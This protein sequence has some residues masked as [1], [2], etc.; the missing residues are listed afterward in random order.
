MALLGLASQPLWPPP[1]ASLYGAFLAGVPEELPTAVLTSFALPSGWGFTLRF[2]PS[3]RA[4]TGTGSWTAADGLLNAP[5]LSAGHALPSP[6]PV[7]SA[8]QHALACLLSLHE[9]SR[10]VDLTRHQLLVR[11]ACEE[12]LGAL[13]KGAQ[14]CPAL[15]DIVMPFLSACLHLRLQQPLF[16]TSPQGQA[17]RPIPPNAHVLALL[18]S[19]TPTLRSM[20]RSLAQRARHSISLDL[21]TTRSNAITPRCY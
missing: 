8:H 19:A 20:V 6:A 4:L 11:C 17:L 16:L 14:H 12:A 1:P 10:H 9:A 18:D 21:F 7:S 3:Q 2:H 13:C 5:W 15:Q